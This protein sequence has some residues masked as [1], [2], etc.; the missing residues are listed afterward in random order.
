MPS[1]ASVLRPAGFHG[2]AALRAHARGRG[3]R[4]YFEG[5]Y[6][7][8]V[9]A[10]RG[11]R[12][13]LIPGVFLS[14]DGSIQESFVQVLDGESGE[15]SYHRF[16]LAQ[17]AAEERAFDVR[18]AANRFTASGLRIE[19]P[20]L[21]G[22][23]RFGPFEHWPVT[24]RSPG[25]MGWY[26]WVPTMEC[27]HGV[28]SLNHALTGSLEHRGRHVDFTGGRGYIETDW[29]TAF[30]QGYI[31]L[32]SNHFEMPEVSLIASTALIPWRGSAFRGDLVGLLLPAEAGRAAR[33]HR[34]T[35]YN[36][37]KTV[38]LTVSDN[39]VH[40]VLRSNDGWL[41]TLNATTRGRGAGLLHAPVRTQMHQRV[42]E[43][44]G[45]RIRVELAR[46][47]DSVVFEGVGRAAGMEVHGAID[48]LLATPGR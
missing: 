17:F 34:F 10:D 21:V 35:S 39:E 31:W 18:V 1:P 26:A 22:E 37:S 38:E 9:S 42:A 15:T 40:W 16:E 23:V 11:T 27:Y 47:G 45:G 24:T 30:P 29:G 36:H 12:L 19:L 33:L 14:E 7:K 44:L 32:Q 8:V 13:A 4:S 5:W 43:T 3:A 46:P 6:V 48:R 28:V 41:L 20:D 25:A 2:H